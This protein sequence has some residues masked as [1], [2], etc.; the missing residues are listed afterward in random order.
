MNE[1]D[2]VWM[3]NAYPGLTFGDDAITGQIEFNARYDVAQHLFFILGSTQCQS[4]GI[5]LGGAFTIRI[6]PRLPGAISRLPALHVE[7]VE[8]I[9][10]RHFTSSDGSACLCSMFDEDDFLVPDFQFKAY[11]QELIVPFLYGQIFYT[12][13]KR[14]P[15]PEYAHGATG[16]LEAYSSMPDGSR[17]H[18]CIESLVRFPDWPRIRTALEQEPYVKGHTPCMC[19]AKDQIRRCHPN[20]LAGM[21]LLKRHIQEQNISLY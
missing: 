16:A 4:D 7:G 15:W 12:R 1:T 14:W 20:A 3:R 19:S 11:L 5:T 18:F 13:Y 17:A 8:V 6:S 10:D 21:R 9:A 2:L